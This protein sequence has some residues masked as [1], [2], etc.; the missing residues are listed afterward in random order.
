MAAREFASGNLLAESGAGINVSR[1]VQSIAAQ[2]KLALSAGIYLVTTLIGVLIFLYPF[3][4]GATPQTSQ[5]VS[6][7]IVLGIA[8]SLC[9]AALAVESQGQ[10]LSAKIVALLGVLIALNS[11]LRM[12]E[13]ALPTPGGFTPVFLLIILSGYVFGARFGFLMG[14]LSLLVSALFTAGVGPWLPHQMFTA[15]WMGM[16]AGWLNRLWSQLS[17]TRRGELA[18]LIAF[19]VVWGFL[20]GAIMNLWFWPFQ[21]GS[22]D[23]SYQ[24]GLSAGDTLQRYAVFYVATSLAWDVFAA[25]GNAVLLGVF[26]AATLKALRRFR[27]RFLFEID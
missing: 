23:Q 11:V 10:A 26:G 24:A 22:P 13:T 4:T 3:L 17:P 27:N 5:L 7:P 16:S 14:A 15:G 19:G 21:A 25:A 9:L 12:A 1:P 20:Y 18:A 6:S 8:I 2:L